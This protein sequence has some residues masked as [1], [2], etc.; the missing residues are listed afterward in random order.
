MQFF[1]SFL[2]GAV[3]VAS[4]QS[5]AK[6]AVL[7]QPVM[8]EAQLLSPQTKQQLNQSLRVF[9]SAGCGSGGCFDCSQFKG[10]NR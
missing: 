5:V 6:V 4:F 3:L 10:R 2:V 9:K 7:R 8:D 1:A